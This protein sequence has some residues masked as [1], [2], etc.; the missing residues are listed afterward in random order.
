[1]SIKI[2]FNNPLTVS[3]INKDKIYVQFIEN[4]RFRSLKENL[5]ISYNYEIFTYIPP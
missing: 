3:Q 5:Y 2:T 4:K 1:M